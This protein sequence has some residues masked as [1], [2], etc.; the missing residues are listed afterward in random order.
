MSRR[1]Q[2]A[3]LTDVRPHL[4]IP[5]FAKGA[6]T[7]YQTQLVGHLDGYFH[8]RLTGWAADPS[9]GRCRRP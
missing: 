9:E 4:Q 5:P 1:L 8:G 2:V 3:C 7:A 6:L